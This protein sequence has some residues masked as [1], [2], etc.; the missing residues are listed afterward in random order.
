MFK[1]KF[2]S[3]FL[4]SVIVIMITIT[5]VILIKISAKVFISMDSFCIFLNHT[6]GTFYTA[7]K[8]V[9]STCS[10]NCLNTEVWQFWWLYHSKLTWTKSGFSKLILTK[11]GSSKITK[12]LVVGG[13][14]LDYKTSLF[15]DVGLSIKY[16][17][18]RPRL[19]GGNKALKPLSYVRKEVIFFFFK[20][21]T[22]PLP[23][24]FPYKL[25]LSSSIKVISNSLHKNCHENKPKIRIFLKY[26]PPLCNL[27]GS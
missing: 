7:T 6:A 19:E 17:C 27:N 22:P 15:I 10:H 13:G 4:F 24:G 2:C 8:W 23:H 14:D 5:A 3:A 18:I 9:E 1:N 20:Y 26:K 21:I 11:I 25:L 16:F 12:G